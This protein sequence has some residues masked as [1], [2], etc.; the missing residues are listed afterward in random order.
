MVA[1]VY[2]LILSTY[3]PAEAIAGEA[4][5]EDRVSRQNGE[6]RGRH[7]GELRLMPNKKAPE[8]RGFYKVFDQLTAASR[9]APLGKTHTEKGQT[10]KGNT[11]RFRNPPEHYIHGTVDSLIVKVSE[12]N[13]VKLP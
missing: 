5:C 11:R 6:W 13:V 1:C 12:I 10:E 8:V 9:F 4:P 7:D 2:L 3:W